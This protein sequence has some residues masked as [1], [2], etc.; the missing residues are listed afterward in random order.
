[1][2]VVYTKTH[3]GHKQEIKHVNL[4]KKDKDDI[5]RLM[6]L[7]M[8]RDKILQNIRSSLTDQFLSRKHLLRKKDLLN[9]KQSLGVLNPERRHEN[10]PI[11][12]EA[13]IEEKQKES[14]QILIY[15]PQGEV[16]E[17]FPS[18]KDDFLLGIM[19]EGQQHLLEKYGE[20]CIAIDSTHGTNNYDFQLTTIMIIDEN[21]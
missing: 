2:N 10:D 6:I 13:W 7:G 19:T 16:I 12:V 15:K 9:I 5:A 20:K 14:N 4:P 1:M 17:E 11:S 21:K 8:N 3:V 18:F